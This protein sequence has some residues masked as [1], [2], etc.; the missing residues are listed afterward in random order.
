[1]LLIFEHF[2]KIFIYALWGYYMRK[3]IGLIIG[4]QDSDYCKELVKVV[5]REA[6]KNDFD[7][8]IFANYGTYD[9]SVYL[10]G[11][12]EISVYKI[13]DLDSF[14]GFILDETLYNIENMGEIVY[15]Y[16][17][18]NATCPVISL[19]KRTNRFYDILVE[20]RQGIKSMTEHFI[21]KHG[22]TKICHMTGRWEL[23]DARERYHG[24]EDAMMEADLD[25]TNDMVFYG[26]YW[27]NKGAEA[28]EYFSKNGYPEAIVCAN[29]YM[30]ISVCT[31]LAKRGIKVPEDICV[32]GF[33]DSEEG[34]C[35]NIPLTTVEDDIESFALCAIRTLEKAIAGEDVVKEQ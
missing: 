11:E 12:G 26:D 5:T 2:D 9:H 21:K 1:M 17:D 34:R 23:Q 27:K 13:P 24:Y 15:S 18:K 10:Y 19:K 6:H 3:R 7:V 4:E 8:F 22:F 31:E 16:F 29:D 14:D 33:D 30:A 35:Q 28:V 32:S 25:I 20:D